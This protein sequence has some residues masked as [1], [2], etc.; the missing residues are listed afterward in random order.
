[1]KAGFTFVEFFIV[2]AIIGLLAAIIVPGV[3]KNNAKKIDL[4][5]QEPSIASPTAQYKIVIID[6]CQYVESLNSTYAFVDI[7]TLCHK[8]D[9]SNPI[10]H[11]K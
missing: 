9:C 7:H 4:E 11:Q 2:L 6:G 3:M 1:M 10:H 8:G 5:K